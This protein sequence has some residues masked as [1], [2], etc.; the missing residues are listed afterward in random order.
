MT[1]P[2]Q[3]GI[4][5]DPRHEDGTVRSPE[6]L[7]LSMWWLL[8]LLIIF[9]AGQRHGLWG[10]DEPRD[11]EIAREMYASSDWVIPRLNGMQFLE[12]PPLAYW[13]AV[14]VFRVA[15]RA[16]V[17]ICRIPSAIWGLIG[18]LA[19]AWLGS[20]LAGR[21]AGLLAALILATTVEWIYIT[22][23]LL[24]DVPLA[25][26]VALSFALFWY[27]Y[28][29]G[30][31]R[32]RLGYLGCALAMGGAFMAKG[33][34]GI[35]IPAV[36]IA[37]F[38]AW[39]REWRECARLLSLWN[40]AAL[41]ATTLPW[42]CLLAKRGGSEA[43]H[44]FLWQNQFL[45]F[46]SSGA[47]HAEP[48]WYYLP[49]LF[50]LLAPWCV[51]L[52]VALFRL[53][54]PCDEK[55]RGSAGRQYLLSAVVVPFILLSIASG[56][57]QLYLLPLV[58]AWSLMIAIWV[59]GEWHPLQPRWELLWRD[60]GLALF[61]LLPIGAWSCA[62][63]FALREG[64]GIPVAIAGLIVSM[65]IAIISFLPRRGLSGG[66][67]AGFAIAL[68]VM[69]YASVLSPSL[70]MPFEQKKGYAPLTLMLDENV[71]NRDMLYLYTPGEREI[72]VVGFHFQSLVHVLNS[73]EE[74]GRVL[75]ASPGNYV[76]IREKLFGEL[77]SLGSLPS[78]AEV[79]ARADIPHRNL[80]LLRGRQK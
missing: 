59:M 55:G 3:V 48:P 73:P 46:F 7:S 35:F 41:A 9:F 37:A 31:A 54:R 63:Y 38:L 77:I 21:R 68:L 42:I 28:G 65:S 69:A 26:C 12:K 50:E 27:G 64:P 71:K 66:R 24:V 62:L 17:E 14:L 8:A 19:T 29:A 75:S 47:D 18:A 60:K 5:G 30:G 11:A 53:I 61:S 34:V 10:G 79:V 49:L 78:S 43:L 13:G 36:A 72:G 76:L 6:R 15:G 33:T 58:P 45:R 57:R 56:K 16:S 25:S 4:S 52:P 80:L 2:P 23:L 22:H 1:Y 40:I 20:M 44:V 74:I 67:R 51:F 39:R 32:K 70:W